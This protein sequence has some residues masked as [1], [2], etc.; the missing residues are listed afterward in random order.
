MNPSFDA[1]YS[2]EPPTA[3][4]FRKSRR[5]AIP[6]PFSGERVRA[7]LCTPEVNGRTA[8]STA[9]VRGRSCCDGSSTEKLDLSRS[10]SIRR[11]EG[12]EVP[13]QLLL[14]YEVVTGIMQSSRDMVGCWSFW[15]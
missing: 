13:G 10:L 1:R 6:T 9:V 2:P 14:S 11:Q 5:V 3:P 8:V 4:A 15:E 7:S 12:K